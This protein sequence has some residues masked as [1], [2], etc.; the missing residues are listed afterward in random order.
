M[1]GDI[2]DAIPGLLDQDRLFQEGLCRKDRLD[3]ELQAAIAAVLEWSDVRVLLPA[4]SEEAEWSELLKNSEPQ[5][6]ELIAGLGDPDEILNRLID[7]G[8][9]R[10]DLGRVKFF[11]PLLERWLHKMRNENRS[12]LL[13]RGTGNWGLSPAEEVGLLAAN[14]WMQFD[15]EL[16]SRCQKAGVPPPLKLK[17]V[18]PQSWTTLTRAVTSRDDFQLFLNTTHELLIDGRE[19]KRAMLKYP[20][21]M[22]AYHRLR[23]VRNVFIHG[24]NPSTVAL[25]AWDQVYFRGVGRLRNGGEPN[26]SEEWRSVQLVLL[27]AFHIGYRNAIAIAG[28]STKRGTAGR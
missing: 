23:L 2:D 20:W 12:L 9:M 16:F 28:E 7:V 27:R 6:A 14:E 22:L 15:A 26:D 17:A 13:V 10:R 5:L 25:G 1:A 21:L 4:L 11:S 8:V 19:D 3:T 24:A 18:Q